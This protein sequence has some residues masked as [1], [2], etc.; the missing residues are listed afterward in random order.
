MIPHPKAFLLLE[1]LNKP[2][3][4][5]GDSDISNNFPNSQLKNQREIGKAHSVEGPGAGRWQRDFYER[6]L[7]RKCSTDVIE[8]S[9]R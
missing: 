4:T 3:L 8:G 2:G 9:D 7:E 1:N 5:Y 6:V